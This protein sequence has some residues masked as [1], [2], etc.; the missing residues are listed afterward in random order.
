MITMKNEQLC[1]SINHPAPEELKDNMIK[2]IAAVIRWRASYNEDY[3]G[4]DF[5]LYILSMLLAELVDTKA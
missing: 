1:I 2:T 4:D 5:N 3:K